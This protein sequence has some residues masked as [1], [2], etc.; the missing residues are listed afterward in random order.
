MSTLA[1]AQRAHDAQ[2]PEPDAPPRWVV[3]VDSKGWYVVDLESEIDTHVR[4]HSERRALA[5]AA[6][7]NAGG[8]IWDL[9]EALCAWDSAHPDG[10]PLSRTSRPRQGGDLPGDSGRPQRPGA[11]AIQIEFEI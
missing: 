8:F 3:D 6:E 9:D 7:L 5:V 4:C 11:P 1:Q 10:L 2:M